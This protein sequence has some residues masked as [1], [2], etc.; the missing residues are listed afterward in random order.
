M[1]MH[2]DQNP[3]YSVDDLILIYAAWVAYNSAIKLR[4]DLLQV[5]VKALNRILRDA[6]AARSSIGPAPSTRPGPLGVS[7]VYPTMRYAWIPASTCWISDIDAL[8]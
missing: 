6:T 5:V 4:G 7:P 1:G 3:T 2:P 8:D